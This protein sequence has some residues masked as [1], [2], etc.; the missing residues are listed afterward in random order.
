MIVRMRLK[1]DLTITLL[2][3][4]VT[5]LLSQACASQKKLQKIKAEKES[6]EIMPIKGDADTLSSL[7]DIPAESIKKVDSLPNNGDPIIMNAIL[8]EATG[9]MVATEELAAAMIVSRRYQVAERN[10]KVDLPFDIFVPARLLDS[11]WQLRLDP[12]MTLQGTGYR[13]TTALEPVYITGG[14]YRQRQFKGYEQYERFLSSI[15]TDSTLMIHR[16]QL[17]LFIKRNIPQVYA[18]KADSTNV[19]DAE[20]RSRF[21]V[22]AAEALEHYTKGW[23]VRNNE[24]RKA[25]KDKKFKQYVKAPIVTEGIRLDTV[26]MEPNGDY[27]YRYVQTINTRKDLKYAYIALEGALYDQEKNIYKMPRTDSI[28]F[29]ISSLSHFVKD[30]TRYKMKTI[31]RKQEANSSYDINFALGK[32][33]I[34]TTLASNATEINRIKSNLRMLMQDAEFDLDSIIVHASCSPEG[35]IAINDRLSKGRSASVSEFF[36]GFMKEYIDSTARESGFSIDEEGNIIKSEK[37]KSVPFIS[38][39]TDENWDL[40]DTLIEHDKTMTRAEKDKYFEYAAKYKGKLD[41]RE[42]AMKNESWYTYMKESLYPKLRVV[43]FEFYLHRKGMV[44]DFIQT[45]EVDTEYAKGVQFLRDRDYKSA[46]E[47]LQHYEDYN[48]AVAFMAMDRNLSALQCLEKETEETAD[49]CYLKAIIL[50]RFGRDDEACEY[51]KKACEMEKIYV[52]RGNL[53]PEIVVLIKKYGL[54]QQYN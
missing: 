38:K 28:E 41:A 30:I 36:D 50:S 14:E 10:G 24:R 39:Y 31:W 45:E 35:R 7:T 53:D 19:S 52:F 3:V 1:T 40:L 4:A 51:Y 9:E 49:I 54:N 37:L 13:D 46:L 32:S 27:I 47:I 12:D 29:P 5:V 44:E 48:A 11:R 17:D 15:I 18:L 2:A 20:F 26:I 21:N 33:V 25:G 34:D 16:K 22:S 23:K 8:D 43:N 6:A 42:W